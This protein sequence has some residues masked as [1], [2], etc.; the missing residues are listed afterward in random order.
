MPPP[1][2]QTV[3]HAAADA[4]P[5]Q[6]PS[7]PVRAAGR[8]PPR[9]DDARGEDRPDDPGRARRHRRRHHQDHH[10][11]PRQRAVRRRVGAHPQH[12]DGLGRHGRPLPGA[13][14]STP[15]SRIPLLYGI[16]TVHGDGNMLG[17]TVFP[18]NIGLGATRDPA[19]VARRR[20]HRRLRDPVQR[21]RSGPSRPASAWR[22]T[23]AGDAPTSPSVRRRRSSRA[24]GD[25][26][27]RLPG[28]ARTPLRQRP[29]AGHRQALRRRRPHDVRHRLQPAVDRQLPDRPGRRPGQPRDVPPPGAGALR[30]G[31]QAAPRRLGD[32]VVLRR[33]LDRGRPRQPDQHARQ[34]RPDHRVAQ[35]PAALQA[36]W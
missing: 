14:R 30:A 24:D 8:R 4:L 2:A 23:T 12:P 19:L 34:Q 3:T 31:D 21:T 22:A 13:P 27:R 9:A 16:D 20:A 11:Q 36:A 29:G 5:Y 25:R 35:G 15:G 18:H 10:R 7:L 28:P 32:A 6:D 17:A 26:D 1:T 33:R